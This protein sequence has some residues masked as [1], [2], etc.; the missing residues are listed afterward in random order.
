MKKIVCHVTLFCFTLFYFSSCFLHKK[1]VDID[2]EKS[3]GVATNQLRFF[4]LKN[5][6]NAEKY[7]NTLNGKTRIFNGKIKSFTFSEYDG[8]EKPY[9]VKEEYDSIGN[10]IKKF[11][12]QDGF[13]FDL[14]L[15]VIYIDTS[16]L[17][18]HYEKGLVKGNEIIKWSGNQIFEIWKDISGEI[19]TV[20]I[21]V[22]HEKLSLVDEFYMHSNDTIGNA[23]YKIYDQQGNYIEYGNF[24]I[25]GYF[26][27][28]SIELL[29]S[30]LRIPIHRFS[31]DSSGCLI[32]FI[33]CSHKYQPKEYV[34]YYDCDHGSA[35]RGIDS[36][37]HKVVYEFDEH[38]NWI[39]KNVIYFSEYPTPKVDTSIITRKIE[40]FEGK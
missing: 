33:S 19:D 16:I 24:N 30:K 8:T 7:D 29:S 37:T 36:S 25:I 13:V 6:V 2:A 3:V 11:R 5:I 26:P 15:E 23:S 1:N 22:L 35:P 17:I 12:S 40:Y 20:V 4:V 38:N 39:K 32:K 10:L 27:K 28:D 14:V 21:N 34:Q 31:Y 9:Y 18:T